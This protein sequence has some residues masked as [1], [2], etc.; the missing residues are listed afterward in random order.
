VSFVRVIWRLLKLVAMFAVRGAELA[1]KRPSTRAEGADWLHRFCA[2]AMREMGIEI[3]TVGSFPEKGAVISNHLSYLDI[4]IFA[5]L[6]PCVFVSKLEVKSWPVIGWMTVKA[7]TVFVD[8]GHG[9]SALRAG[10]RM[11]SAME[12]GV[13]VVFFP[14]GTT[15][16]GET[17]LKFHTGL[18]AKVL[19]VGEPVTTAYLRYSLG[20]GNEPGADVR[21]DVAYWGDMSMGAHVFRLLGL[22]NVKATIWFADAP[23]AFSVGAMQRKVAAVEAREAMVALKE[24]AEENQELG[25]GSARG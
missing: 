14:E 19:E 4:V 12:Q 6:R 10:S 9:G 8:R 17:L 11:Q 15:T 13:P 23:I 1:I 22:R 21:N 24:K 7:G 16:N 25:A 20:E 18:L 5:A 3:E 2:Q